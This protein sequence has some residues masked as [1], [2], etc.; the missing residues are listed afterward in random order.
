MGRNQLRRNKGKLNK[1]TKLCC[2]IKA[3]AYGH[4]TFNLQNFVRS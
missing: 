4:G 2:V 3:N 1:E